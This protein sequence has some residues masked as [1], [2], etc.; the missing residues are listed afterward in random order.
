MYH[1]FH[2]ISTNSAHCII[3]DFSEGLTK[4]VDKG[5]LAFCKRHH[6]PKIEFHI[7][8]RERDKKYV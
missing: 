8:K 7:K 5:Y 4:Q 6:V 2:G 3:D 1:R